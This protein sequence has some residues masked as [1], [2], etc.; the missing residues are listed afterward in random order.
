MAASNNVG[1]DFF[2]TA[3]VPLLL[4]REF[5]SRD[6]PGAPLVAIINEAFA[7]KYFPGQNPL[8]RRFGD[9][10]PKSAGKFEIVGV[11]KDGRFQSLRLAPYP[12]E[13]QSFWQSTQHVP[14]VLHVRVMGNTGAT[15]ASVG[16]AIRGIDPGLVVYDVRTMTEQV[17]GT[18]RPE[19]TFAMLSLLFGALALGL[20][21]VGLYGVTAYSVTRRTHEI[22]IRMALGAARTQ[23]LCLFLRETLGL[24]IIGAVIGTPIALAC[25]KFVKSLLFGLAPGDPASLAIALLMLAGVA[26]VACLLPARRATKVDPM[27]ALRYE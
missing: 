4:G 25:A 17:N 9:Q 7:R 10:G 13:F 3:G 24:V 12:A 20:C 8:G 14:F 26:T 21:C 23:V 18:L 27:V 1:P 6:R 11:V 5:S 2:A 22:G 15:A 16:Q 19:R